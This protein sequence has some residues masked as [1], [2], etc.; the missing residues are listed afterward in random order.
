VSNTLP[1]SLL[2]NEN[3]P[4]AA[5]GAAAPTSPTGSATSSSS[6]ASLQTTFLQLLVA[7]LQ[8][9]DP[10]SPLDSSQMTSQL[11]QIDTVTGVNQLNTTLNSLATQL[12]ANQSTGAAALVGG[13]VL[14]PGD[15]VTVSTDSSGKQVATPFGVTLTSAVP[16]LTATVTNSSGTVV[17]TENLGKQAAGTIP[18]TFTPTDS[19]GNP[20]PN[21]TYTIALQTPGASSSA[22]PPTVLTA[23][24]VVSVL[25]Q[26]D[27][28][29]GLLLSNGQTV[30]LAN[31]PAIL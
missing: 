22:T 3:N 19:S 6:P 31:V 9:Q 14:T 5:P 8:N 25:K 28:S 23:S 21:G 26:P 12:Q 30:G 1:S 2:N 15:T 20:L 24:E 11:A 10:T 29:T 16:D 27:G 13:T 17:A 18:I 7:Q 4:S